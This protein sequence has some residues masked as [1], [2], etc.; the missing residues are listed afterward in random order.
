VTDVALR[1]AAPED[2]PFLRRVYASTRADEL[3]RVPWTDE[4]KR[5]FCDMQFDAQAADYRSRWSDMAY[6]VVLVGGRPAGRFWRTFTPENVHVLDLAILPEFRGRGAGTA[7]L[8]SVLD[9]A[10]AS[11]RTASIS[12]E[13]LNRA[14]RL[15][16][17]LGFVIVNETDVYYR[18]EWRPS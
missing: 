4:M 8:R 12:V 2:E 3:A 9:E 16:E 11:G 15:Y 6:D 14:R 18:M 13:K 17:R 10:A 5:A 1:P 7:L